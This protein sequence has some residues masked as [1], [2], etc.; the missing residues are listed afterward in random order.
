M[1]VEILTH[2]LGGAGGQAY[3]TE[4]DVETK[5]KRARREGPRGQRMLLPFTHFK[6]VAIRIV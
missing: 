6:K 4:E 1:C 3:V 5:R 2:I